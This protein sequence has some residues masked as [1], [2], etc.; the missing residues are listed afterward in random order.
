[1]QGRQT[2]LNGSRTPMKP[3]I[4]QFCSQSMGQSGPKQQMLRTL[5][6]AVVR[7]T[8][9][10]MQ[11]LNTPASA[12]LQVRQHKWNGAKAAR[13]SSMSSWGLTPESCSCNQSSPVLTAAKGHLALQSAITERVF[14]STT[15]R[16]L[17][18]QMSSLSWPTSLRGLSTKMSS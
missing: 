13:D 12:V 11:H 1:M 8:T 3:P 17:P 2:F 14:C 18:P 15:P 4:S 16:L 9:F 7:M 5:T 10:W 6:G